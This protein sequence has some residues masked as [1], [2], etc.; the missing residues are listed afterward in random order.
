MAANAPLQ[1]PNE[2]K[3]SGYDY[4]GLANDQPVDL[5]LTMD[6]NQVKTGSQTTVLKA[7]R[8]GKAT[9]EQTRTGGLDQLGHDELVLSKDGIHVTNSSI[10]KVDP[11]NLEF[12]FDPQPGFT[13]TS[14]DKID[15]PGQHFDVTSK[16][17]VEG[18]KDVDTKGGRKHALLVTSSGKGTQ[19]GVPVRI[20]TQTYYVKGFGVVK[21]VIDTT[22]GGKHSRITQ[23]I[24]H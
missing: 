1:V 7:V 5:E 14:H 8:D 19:N 12:P 16:L 20:D 15:D 23:Q 2:L 3:G 13:W 9:F 22:A 21:Q 17:V 10:A 24:S 4:Y 11:T 6:D 18:F